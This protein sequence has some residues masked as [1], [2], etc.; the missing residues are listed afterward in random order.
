V[1]T[2]GD[3]IS[4]RYRD[5]KDPTKRGTYL[6]I[7]GR[8]DQRVSARQLSRYEQ[9]QLKKQIMLTME[10]YIE[11]G[12][13]TYEKQIADDH[14]KEVK[15]TSLNIVIADIFKENKKWEKEPAKE[16]DYLAKDEDIDDIQGII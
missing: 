15:E 3:D 2:M 8:Q 4:F 7:N 6:L 1:I 14:I 10:G 11:T 5:Y 13:G 9:N 12:K 16:R